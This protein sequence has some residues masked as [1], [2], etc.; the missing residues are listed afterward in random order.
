MH[1]ATMKWIL[2]LLNKNKQFEFHLNTF[3]TKAFVYLS[4]A[5][6]PG[7]FSTH[8]VYMK[9]ETEENIFAVERVFGSLRLA[10]SF[11]CLLLFS[12]SMMG[13]ISPLPR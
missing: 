4:C 5:A 12:C 10:E 3:C 9:F 6:L 8:L 1:G 2:S 11:L 7:S 13:S